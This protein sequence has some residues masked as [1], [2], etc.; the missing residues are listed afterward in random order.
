MRHR[1]MLTSA[2]QHHELASPAAHP[3]Y[4][5]VADVCEAYP[6]QAAALLQTYLDLT[7]AAAAWQEVEPCELKGG[8]SV[9]KPQQEHSSLAGI[10]ENHA[11]AMV[12]DSLT[13]WQL[14][15]ARLGVVPSFSELALAALLG[16]RKDSVSLASRLHVSVGTY[17]S[18]LQQKLSEVIVPLSV[19]H[20]LEPSQ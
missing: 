4:E 20:H 18:F 17:S 2:G 10:T 3:S 15:S 1:V 5:A 13:Q 19:T 11:Q 14:S 8:A 7:H 6:T 9:T 16:R 12:Q